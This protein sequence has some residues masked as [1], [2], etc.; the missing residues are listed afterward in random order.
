MAGPSFNALNPATATAFPVFAGDFAPAV[1]NAGTDTATVAG[2]IYYN[3]VYVRQGMTVTSV[4]INV[5][6]VGGTDLWIAVIYGPDGNKI[7]TSTTAGTTAGTANS[8][9]EIALTAPINLRGPQLY[10]VALQSNGTTAK[11]RLGVANGSRAGSQTGAFATIAA[12]SSLPTAN[13][14][15]MIAYLV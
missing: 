1:L 11:V 15:G 10:Y 2:T 3:A 9:Q 8:M 5:G 4:G 6:S 13:A 7:A 12:I 14:G